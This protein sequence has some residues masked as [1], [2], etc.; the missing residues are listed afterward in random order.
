M[1]MS[2]EAL[3]AFRCYV[4]AHTEMDYTPGTVLTLLD[5]IVRLR[6]AYENLYP[7]R[8]KRGD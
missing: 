8:P 3:L 6:E 5:E 7:V 2:D 4:V 1:M